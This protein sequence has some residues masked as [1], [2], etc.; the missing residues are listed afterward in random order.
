MQKKSLPYQFLL[1]YQ[2]LIG[3]IISFLVCYFFIDRPLAEL[4]ASLPYGLK[5]FAEFIGNIFKGA[6]IIP[7][8]LLL[9]ASFYFF[10]PKSKLWQKFTILLSI[11]L[12]NHVFLFFLKEI[13]GRA[14]PYLFLEQGIYGF[15]YFIHQYN[16]LSFPSGHTLIAFS[17]AGFFGYIFPRYKISYMVFAIVVALSRIICQKHYLSD[18]IVSVYIALCSIP[19]IFYLIENFSALKFLKKYLKSTRESN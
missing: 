11:L 8:F 10:K 14:R 5:V 3:I 15:F 18:V 12:M 7:F 2:W 17:I 6:F 4:T 1:S 13:F 16:Y 9:T 19:I